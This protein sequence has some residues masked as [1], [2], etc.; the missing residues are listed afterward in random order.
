[1]I[2]E[3]YSAVWK[4]LVYLGQIF[5]KI[6]VSIYYIYIFCNKML[7]LPS[8]RWSTL[9]YI[10]TVVISTATTT[11]NNI[12]NVV[13]SEFV[14]FIQSVLQLFFYFH[15]SSS[16]LVPPLNLPGRR[17]LCVGTQ[18][19]I[20]TRTMGC[21]DIHVKKRVCRRTGVPFINRQTNI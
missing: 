7:Q 10:T 17:I 1:M 13:T 14:F 2:F 12:V 3:G 18:L 9:L 21:G 6:D 20:K 8:I 16:C 15:F 4:T 11:A 19:I 5:T